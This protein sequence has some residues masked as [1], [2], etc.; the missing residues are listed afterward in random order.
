MKVRKQQLMDD[1]K[2]MNWFR[3]I[4]NPNSYANPE[5]RLSIPITAG[6]DNKLEYL[7]KPTVAGLIAFIRGSMHY[8]EKHTPKKES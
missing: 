5:E 6:D 1:H 3:L 4:L 7:F 8:L 2:V